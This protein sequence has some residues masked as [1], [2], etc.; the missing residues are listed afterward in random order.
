M[1]QVSINIVSALK[2]SLTPVSVNNKMDDNSI[3]YIYI[4]IY[5]HTFIL[6][7]KK[8]MLWPV[9]IAVLLFLQLCHFNTEI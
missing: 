8:Y 5:T 9:E 6:I 4:Y 1:S 7:V 3:L 2:M